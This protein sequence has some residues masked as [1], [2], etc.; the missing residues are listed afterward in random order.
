MGWLI[1]VEQRSESHAHQV[2]SGTPEWK[3]LLVSDAMP[4]LPRRPQGLCSHPVPS[5]PPSTVRL[6]WDC[7]EAPEFCCRP[8]PVG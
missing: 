3:G 1:M 6:G 7:M 5:P 4:E 8:T 2:W